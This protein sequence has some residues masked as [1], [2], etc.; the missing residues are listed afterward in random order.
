MND[1][2]KEMLDYYK[3]QNS[4]EKWT[5]YFFFWW[6]IALLAIPIFILIAG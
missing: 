3:R 6:F 5:A 4:A 2:N 1:L